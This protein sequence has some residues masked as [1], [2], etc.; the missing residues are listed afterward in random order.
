MV[1][2]VVLSEFFSWHENN[3]FNARLDDQ[4]VT[5]EEDKCSTWC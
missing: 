2:V 3:Q 1:R 4:S 5:G